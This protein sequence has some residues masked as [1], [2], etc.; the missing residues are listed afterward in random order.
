MLKV[1]QDLYEKKLITYTR[2]SSSVLDESL[3]EKAARVLD[4]IKQGLPYEEEL[5][6]T[7]SKRSFDSKKVESHSA[8][9]PTYV[10]P[11]N[12]SPD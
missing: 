6:F 12:L 3:K 8:I 10:A 2:T 1:A 9:I 7:D 4:T 11:K 5:V